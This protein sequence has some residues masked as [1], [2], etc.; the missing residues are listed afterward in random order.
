[1]LCGAPRDYSGMCDQKVTDLF[2]A[3]STELDAEKRKQKVWDM[4]KYAVP[5]G[6]KLVLA[7]TTYREASWNYVKG[8]VQGP[9][10]GYN[11]SHWKHV[12]MD[13]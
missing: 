3:Q 13:K 5:L 4:E 12:W 2:M 9:S 10:P 11:T 8:Y 7:W 6:I 1:Y